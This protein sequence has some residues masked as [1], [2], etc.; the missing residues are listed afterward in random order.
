MQARSVSPQQR[1]N[2]FWIN[3]AIGLLLALTVFAAAPAIGAFY[4]QPALQP[5]VQALAPS[6]TA[7]CA[8]AAWLPPTSAAR[9]WAS[10]PG[11]RSRCAATATG[12]SPPSSSARRSGTRASSISASGA[13]E[14]FPFQSP[15]PCGR[16]P[17]G[18]ASFSSMREVSLWQKQ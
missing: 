8:S 14:P 11:S 12:R 1:S 2:L 17:R 5:I 18:G 7:T 9:R 13:P 3:S 4:A 10:P 15:R 16:A 6:S